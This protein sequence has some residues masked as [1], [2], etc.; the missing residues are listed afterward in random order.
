MTIECKMR[1]KLYVRGNICQIPIVFIFFALLIIGL[2][3]FFGIKY[4][5]RYKSKKSSNLTMS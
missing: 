5:R 2:L 1:E 4:Y 3:T